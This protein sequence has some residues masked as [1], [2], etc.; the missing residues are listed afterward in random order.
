MAKVFVSQQNLGHREPLPLKRV[1]VGVHER[2]LPYGG[3]GL[4]F[5]DRGRAARKPQQREPRGDRAGRHDH[6]LVPLF[7]ERAGLA[8]QLP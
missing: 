1:A 8:G 5:G 6:Q 2:D 3:D 4:L 7:A